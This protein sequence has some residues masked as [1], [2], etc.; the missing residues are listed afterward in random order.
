MNLIARLPQVAAYVYRRKYH[1]G[2]AIE[3]KADLDWAGNFAHMLGFEG[4][5]F[6]ELMRLLIDVHGFS[7]DRA[8]SIVSKTFGYTNHT[9]L[10]EALESWPVDFFERLLPRHLVII[11]Q[12]NRHFLDEISLAFPGDLDRRR[13]MSLID[14]D[15]GRRVRMAHLAIVASQKVNGVA[16]LHSMLMTETIFHD[17]AQLWPERFTNVTN[18][19][20]F[21][22]WLYAANPA[23]TSLLAE[24][25]GPTVMDDVSVLPAF[26]AH[27]TDTALHDRLA[28]IRLA[29]KQRLA[30]LILDRVGIKVNLRRL[31]DSHQRH[32]PPCTPRCSYDA[33]SSKKNQLV[34]QKVCL[35]E[36]RMLQS[37]WRGLLHLQAAYR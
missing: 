32:E 16:K 36:Q 5:N 10:P 26:A 29:N 23:L 4:Q 15:H 18:G 12:I 1:G 19:I 33:F 37:R 7:W 20:T 13:R 35:L 11:F 3:P 30:G 31:Q 25:V 22:R 27:A 34:A 24:I 28:A 9:L 14:E 21:R 6:A 8:W 17:F 2:K